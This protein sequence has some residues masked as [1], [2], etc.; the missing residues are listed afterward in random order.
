MDVDPKLL[1]SVLTTLE[2]SRVFVGGKMAMG[3][4]GLIVYDKDILA[5]RE[6]IMSSPVSQPVLTHV[7]TKQVKLSWLDRFFTRLGRLMS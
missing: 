7:S 4:A 5:L 1:K 3:K 2:H 6:A